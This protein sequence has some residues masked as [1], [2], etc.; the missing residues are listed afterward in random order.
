MVLTS[1]GILIN[2]LFLP[3]HSPFRFFPL[4]SS[5][6]YFLLLFPQRKII[7]DLLGG[8]A[9]LRSKKELI[10]DVDDIPD[11]FSDFWNRKN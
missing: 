3:C 10:E 5:L 4:V 2:L 7:I 8:E 11:E 9:Q 6:M 1:Y